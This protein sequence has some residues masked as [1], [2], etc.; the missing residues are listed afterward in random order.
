MPDPVLIWYQ[1]DAIATELAARGLDT[2][3]SGT[4]LESIKPRTV[5]ASIAVHGTGSNLQQ[6]SRAIV[7][8]PPSSGDAWEQ[9]LGRLHRPGQT[10]DDVVFYVYQHTDAFSGAMR[11]AVE[12]SGFIEATTGNPQKLLYA[13][14]SMEVER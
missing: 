4:D 2:F 7:I 3:G 12:R 6:W 11:S 5:A 14:K 8:E 9:L 10:A 13:T 1:S